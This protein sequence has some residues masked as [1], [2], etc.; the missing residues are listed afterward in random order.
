MK[1]LIINLIV[2][3]LIINLIVFLL[4]GAK[5]IS[6]NSAL[7]LAADSNVDVPRSVYEEY[8]KYSTKVKCTGGGGCGFFKEPLCYFTGL[9]THLMLPT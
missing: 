5:L 7:K 9:F 3:L 1:E 8:E 2:F 6:F 4:G